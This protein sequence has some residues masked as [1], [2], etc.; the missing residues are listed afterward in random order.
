MTI[1]QLKEKVIL[2]KLCFTLN[3][4]KRNSL[5]KE[6]EQIGFESALKTPEQESILIFYNQWFAVILTLSNILLI[7]LTIVSML[8]T[9][10]YG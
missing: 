8:L 2:L 5:E 1:S 3:K 10:K 4:E 6:L 9:I 7:L